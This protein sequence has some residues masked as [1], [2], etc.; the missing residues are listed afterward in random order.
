ME[1]ARTSAPEQMDG[2]P[3]TPA[4]DFYSLGMILYELATGRTALAGDNMPANI[5]KLRS[6]NLFGKEALSRTAATMRRILSAWRPGAIRCCASTSA[7]ELRAS[8][9]EPQYPH[10]ESGGPRAAADL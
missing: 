6:P 10:R 4:S 3:L 7:A 8:L 1:D 5:M 9:T 2:K